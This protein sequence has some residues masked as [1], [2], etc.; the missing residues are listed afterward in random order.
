MPHQEKYMTLLKPSSNSE[1]PEL[2]PLFNLI[3]E[4]M[5]FVPNSMRTMAHWPELLQHFSQLAAT[6]LNGGV[7]SADLKQ[8]I[9]H[10]T[11]TAS[12]CQY[13]QAHT[14]HQAIKKGVTQEKLMAVF[15]FEDSDLFSAAEK[16]ALKVALHG[17]TSPNGV[18]PKHMET[19]LNHFNHREAVEIISVIALFGFLNRWNDSLATTLE[20]DPLG[21]AQTSLTKR[22]W[23]PGK[24]AT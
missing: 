18:E 19:L 3:S 20:P 9:A 8:L 17:G 24:H 2:K 6:V 4:S 22:G 23:Q 13:C 14:A 11:S 7:L 16:A 10:I 15:E 21:F 12:G 5:G 1:S